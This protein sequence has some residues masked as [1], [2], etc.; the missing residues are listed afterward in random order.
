MSFSVTFHTYPRI[1]ND[2]M[3]DH[4]SLTNTI[5][6]FL[7]SLF[8]DF[9]GNN[10]LFYSLINSFHNHKIA[11]PSE[12]LSVYF[13]ATHSDA[14]HELISVNNVTFFGLPL[15]TSHLLH[16]KGDGHVIFSPEG[17]AVAEWFEDTWE[18]NILFDIFNNTDNYSNR[19]A[20]FKIIMKLFYEQI[21]CKFNSSKSWAIESNREKLHKKLLAMF[22]KHRQELYQ[23]DIASIENLRDDIVRSKQH[24]K[25]L[26]DGLQKHMLSVS[27]SENITSENI[28][29]LINDMDLILNHEQATDIL[30]DDNFIVIKTTPLI[31]HSSDGHTYQSGNY[32]IKIN[33]FDSNIRFTSNKG[34]PG[35]WTNND[36]HPHV[37]GTD[38]S[39]CLGNIESTV[40]ELCSQFQL[41]ALYL[42]LIDYLSSA[43]VTDVAGKYVTNW[44][45][46][47]DNKI[48]D[49]SL[50]TCSCCHDSYPPQN[51]RIAY[52]NVYK[53]DDY[54]DLYVDYDEHVLVCS[55]CLDDHYTYCDEINQYINIDINLEDL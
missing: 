22:E 4:N 1:F 30:I 31:I 49:P 33:L 37:N 16:P 5:T 54:G 43:N 50:E 24:L 35:F 44:P 3:D 10:I 15:P 8:V 34:Y 36:P 46:I 45:K 6:D 29:S 19:V 51:L 53:D 38:G 23:H 39:A 12:K 2:N 17:H 26:Y 42:I 25:Y 21:V 9:T 27:S 28:V 11:I 18:L 55:Y 47:V 32:T 41:Y 48:I 40:V 20:I 7:Q 14:D 52:N 13:N